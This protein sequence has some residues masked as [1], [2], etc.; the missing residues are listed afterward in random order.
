ML[1]PKVLNYADI[2]RETAVRLAQ[3]NGKK[4]EQAIQEKIKRVDSCV[5]ARRVVLVPL[6]S[7]NVDWLTTT[8]FT[9]C[10]R[11]GC[12]GTADRLCGEP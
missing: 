11:L 2:Q 4:L 12:G 10:G 7:T 3:F 6:G 5:Y 9:S 1:Y 8:E